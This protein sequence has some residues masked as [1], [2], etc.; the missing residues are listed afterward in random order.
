MVARSTSN[1]QRV[2]AN[3][4]LIVM[5]FLYQLVEDPILMDYNLKRLVLKLISLEELRPMSTGK[6]MLTIFTLLVM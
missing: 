1:L 4:L 6:Q 5:L 3:K 2:E